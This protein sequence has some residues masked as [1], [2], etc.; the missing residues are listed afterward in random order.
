LI[1]VG[2]CYLFLP[3]DFAACVGNKRQYRSDKQG[4]QWTTMKL[5]ELK[6]TPVPVAPVKA[7]ESLEISICNP[8]KIESSRFS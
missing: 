3:E 5:L 7:K 1:D 2:R 4:R 6:L 8:N